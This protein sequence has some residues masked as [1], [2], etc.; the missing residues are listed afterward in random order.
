[1]DCLPLVYSGLPF[2]NPA[3]RLHSPSDPSLSIALVTF[4]HC[5]YD[6]DR[7]YDRSVLKRD[8]ARRGYEYVNTADWWH[9]L[10]DVGTRTLG[11]QIICRDVEYRLRNLFF[12]DGGW[13]DGEFRNWHWEFNLLVG[14][15]MPRYDIVQCHA[16]VD[17]V[18]EER[19][20]N[21][22]STSDKFQ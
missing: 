15:I 12:R 6:P 9:P 19:E 8:I 18:A 10:F 3:A 22:K 7:M 2:V 1:M 21:V 11:M 17:S 13:Q 20:S 16:T 14:G 4:P 5:V